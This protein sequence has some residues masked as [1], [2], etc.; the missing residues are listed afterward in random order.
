MYKEKHRQA[1]NNY[2]DHNKRNSERD[3]NVHDHRDLLKCIIQDTRFALIQTI[4]S[5]PKQMPSR[6]EIVFATPDKSESTIRQHLTELQKHDIVA[7]VELP[8]E[9]RQRD[10]PRKF[11][12]LTAYGYKT[13]EDYCL[14][15]SETTLREVYKRTEKP[16][17]IEKYENAPRPSADQVSVNIHQS[18]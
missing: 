16:A 12:A 18:I 8:E 4:L 1:R 14:L 11:Y 15:S 5:H 9:Q 2:Q 6:K 13:L 17:D 7:E 3:V 10:L